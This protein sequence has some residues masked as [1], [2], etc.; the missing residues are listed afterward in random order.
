MIFHPRHTHFSNQGV[1]FLCSVNTEVLSYFK[2]LGYMCILSSC[3]R[4]LAVR[5]D[6]WCV[7]QEA[8][9]QDFVLCVPC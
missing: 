9:E 7:A 8:R 5:A 3:Y 2:R 1:L 4:Y 6:S